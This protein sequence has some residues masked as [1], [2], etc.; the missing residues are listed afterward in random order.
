MLAAALLS[1]CTSPAEATDAG[2]ADTGTAN[3]IE[4]TETVT[5]QF[6]ITNNGETLFENSGRFEKGSNAFDAMQDLFDVE[7]R[8]FAFGVMVTSI[9]GT[10]AGEN[11]YWALYVNNEY[12][13]R[14]IT[15]YVLDSDMSFEW[16]IEQLQDAQV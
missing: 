13:D 8:Q 10:P 15:D 11:A 2:T 7:Y 6:G 16:R 14:G 4:K 5:A 12:A 3:T 1:G 9:N